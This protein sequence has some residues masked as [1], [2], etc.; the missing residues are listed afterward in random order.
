MSQRV[1]GRILDLV[2]A[3]RHVAGNL[4]LHRHAVLGIVPRHV[5]IDLVVDLQL[6][7]VRQQRGLPTVVLPTGLVGNR[8]GREA[9]ICLAV[10]VMDARPIAF[11]LLPD[12]RRQAASRL[13]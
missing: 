8:P 12:I 11:R 7:D 13:A 10:V 6:L 4:S 9:L 2:D 3:W 1:S 5:E